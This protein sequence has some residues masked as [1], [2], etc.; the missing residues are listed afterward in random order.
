MKSINSY[1]NG[2]TY[3]ATESVSAMPN[4]KVIITFLDDAPEKSENF[5]VTS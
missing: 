2:T 3:V 5:N 4:Q 1:Y